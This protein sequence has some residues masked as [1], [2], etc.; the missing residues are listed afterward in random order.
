MVD[1]ENG[2][3]IRLVVHLVVEVCSLDK[4]IVTFLPLNM[5]VKTA[6]AHREKIVPAGKQNVQVAWG[7][8][9][10]ITTHILYLDSGK[11]KNL[12]KAKVTKKYNKFTKTGQDDGLFNM[13]TFLVF[14]ISKIIAANIVKGYLW[15][16]FTGFINLR[17]CKRNETMWG[18]A[19]AK[20]EGCD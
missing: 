10:L 20:F 6:M 7:F 3:I 11:H 5:V 9:V 16:R 14:N 17:V 19:L 4:E 13:I 12:R 18:S 15:L 8:F 2:L 1:L